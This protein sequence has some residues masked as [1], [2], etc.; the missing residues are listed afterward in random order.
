MQYNTEEEQKHSMIFFILLWLFYL[1]VY[2]F[3]SSYS[4][5]L[6]SIFSCSFNRLLSM[7][8]FKIIFMNNIITLNYYNN[9]VI[10][11]RLQYYL[12]Q[13]LQLSRS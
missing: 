13:A 8:R 6:I 5:L 9:N 11:V 4:E 10:K 2:S 3:Y 12:R 7:R 1:F